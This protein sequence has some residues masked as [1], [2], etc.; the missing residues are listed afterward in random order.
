MVGYANERLAQ[1]AAAQT[2]YGRASR[3]YDDSTDILAKSGGTKD[4]V[5]LNHHGEDAMYRSALWSRST[6]SV[7]SPD[8][9]KDL[10][11]GLNFFSGTHT[12]FPPHRLYVKHTRHWP[13]A[14]RPTKALVV[15]RSL[16]DL[17][18]EI[19]P[20]PAAPA[21]WYAEVSA[22]NQAEEAILRNTTSLPPAGE[23]NKLYLDFLDD[24]AE[25]WRIGGSRRE[26]AAEVVDVRL[27]PLLP[28]FFFF[29]LN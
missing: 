25:G 4:D 15:R 14:F 26:G 27:N 20:L 12:S 23:V 24:V 10:A 22:N 7:T 29:F 3:V 16:R 9:S 17:L 11:N 13:I 18:H 19:G 8:A 6:P 21:N 2:A 5:T 1:F 28:V